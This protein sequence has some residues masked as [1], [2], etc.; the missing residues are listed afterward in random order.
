M[1]ESVA[2]NAAL[3]AL[4]DAERNDEAPEEVLLK[5]YRPAWWKCPKSAQKL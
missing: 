1:A 4:W 5:S 2:S 3:R